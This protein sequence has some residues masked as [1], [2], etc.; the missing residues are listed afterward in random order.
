MRQRDAAHHD[1]ANAAEE[2][3]VATCVHREDA[4]FY[5]ETANYGTESEPVLQSC[6]FVIDHE[7]VK[8]EY[9]G[10][11]H[12]TRY[13]AAASD[14]ETAD[15]GAENDA[16]MR[17]ATHCSALHYNATHQQT[18]PFCNFL[19]RHAATHC[20]SLQ[21]SDDGT[22]H[23]GPANDAATPPPQSHDACLPATRLEMAKVVAGEHGGKVR[24]GLGNTRTEG[25][26][27]EEAG[28]RWDSW[29]PLKQN[30]TSAS[31]KEPYVVAKEPCIFG[32]EPGNG[33]VGEGTGWTGGED[34]QWTAS[35]TREAGDEEGKEVGEVEGEEV[36]KEEEEWE[37]EEDSSRLA[38]QTVV[39]QW[40]WRRKESG[41]VPNLPHT[42]E[43][44]ST[45]Y[46]GTS[47][48]SV[49]SPSRKMD[50]GGDSGTEG[51][52]E[53]ASASS[54]WEEAQRW[55]A[56][57][58][59]ETNQTSTPAKDPYVSAHESCIFWKEGGGWNGIDSDLE[60]EFYDRVRSEGREQERARQLARMVDIL[61]QCVAVCCN[62]LQCV[63]VR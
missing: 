51:G 63:A 56:R 42:E 35:H 62:V 9:H 21:Y 34:V 47:I 1:I 52:V 32:K 23:H 48:L 7:A 45:Q 59:F 53:I 22:A 38:A 49:L 24:G 4:A 37:G 39:V 15:Y 10:T 11:R 17:T 19:E 43:E 55:D 8:G 57:L 16:A 26:A 54:N 36:G 25:G 44:S 41:N 58:F 30:Q 40:D 28:L 5:I 29:L 61:L 3:V 12:G 2:N 33:G 27:I 20:N 13:E 31:A 6:A 18:S 14:D 50:G 46:M 60:E